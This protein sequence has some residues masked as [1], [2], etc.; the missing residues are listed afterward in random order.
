M[1]TR[2][3]KMSYTGKFTPTIFWNHTNGRVLN[4]GASVHKLTS[5][6]FITSQYL[7]WN[8][9]A[10]TEIHFYKPNFSLILFLWW[11]NSLTVA[12]FVWE[13][14]SLVLSQTLVV[15]VIWSEHHWSCHFCSS[16]ADDSPL[17]ASGTPAYWLRQC[18]TPTDHCLLQH[19][20]LTCENSHALWQNGIRKNLHVL[21]VLHGLFSQSRL[22]KNW[23]WFW[24]HGWT[25][26]DM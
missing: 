9:L 1:P 4:K 6:K 3:C 14:L 22:W 24:D 12:A 19:V 10:G 15:K 11:G 21:A 23:V 16:V 18:P 17:P 8:N 25:K 26:S 7:L 20:K 5:H 2:N 13:F